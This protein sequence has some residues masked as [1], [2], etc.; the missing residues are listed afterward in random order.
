MC[1]VALKY[2]KKE[3]LNLIDLKKYL[4]NAFVIALAGISVSASMYSLQGSAE[5]SGSATKSLT[6]EEID[7]IIEDLKVS[8]NIDN[9]IE[10]LDEIINRAELSGN[11]ALK[12][13]AESTKQAYELQQQLDTLTSNI[14]AMKK[15]N[16]EIDTLDGELKKVLSVSTI[17]EDLQGALSDE[18][19]MVL[20]SLDEEG[21]KALQETVAEIENLVDLN[22]I[23]SL[24]LGQRSLLD[25]LMLNEALNQELFNEE[26]TKVAKEALEV[27]VTV[28]KSEQ[29]AKYTNEQYSELSSGSQDFSKTGKKAAAVLPEQVVFFDGAFNL[30]QA[31]VMYDGHILLAIDDLYQYIDAKVEY[32][33]NN[34]NMVIQS[35]G[36]TL[37]LTAGKNVAYVNDAPKNIP[38][39]VLSIN[40]KTYISGEFFAETYGISY[41]FVSDPGILI[42][43]KNLNQ[44]SNPSIPNQVN[45]D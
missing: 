40:D 24:T 12:E 2:H 25:L 4:R 19:L 33:Y 20:Q 42:M 34:A 10:K 35:P 23:N 6:S 9:V 37:E 5:D 30:T 7:K 43:Y 16:S 8:T 36:V 38:A 17:L 11:S 26:R 32:M 21:I 29:K 15:K 27:A 45:R 3:V 31:P 41:R 39:P 22:D 28:L 13:Y 44:L 18:A 1:D 14:E